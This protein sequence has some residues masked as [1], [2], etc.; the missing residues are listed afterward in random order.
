MTNFFTRRYFILLIIITASGYL[1]INAQEGD[2]CT[3]Q[4]KKL[5]CTYN[6]SVLYGEFGASSQLQRNANFNKYKPDNAFDNDLST[7]WVEGNSRDGL[8]DKLVFY[9]F[10]PLKRLGI[11]PGYGLAQ[12]FTLNNRVKSVKLSVYE[13]AARHSTQC[14]GMFYTQ[15]RLLSIQKLSLE[16][17]MTM[18]YFTLEAVSESSEGYMYSMEITSVYPGSRYRDTCIAEV[19]RE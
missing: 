14:L 2:D 9:S 12:Y 11:L 13:T 4:D 15:G 16:D 18:Q 1:N 10:T 7:A 3:S 6:G 5:R 8:G 19:S 17:S